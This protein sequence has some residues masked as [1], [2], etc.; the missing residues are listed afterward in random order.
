[1]SYSNPLSKNINGRIQL[2]MFLEK[3]SVVNLTVLVYS[4]NL[5]AVAMGA[6]TLKGPTQHATMAA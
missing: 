3:R 5:R 1:M 4:R 6:A 2:L